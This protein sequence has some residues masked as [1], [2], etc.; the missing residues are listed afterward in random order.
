MP[1][2]YSEKYYN[3]IFS[4]Y[5]CVLVAIALMVNSVMMVMETDEEDNQASV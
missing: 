4:L 1:K 5:L 3:F 2:Q